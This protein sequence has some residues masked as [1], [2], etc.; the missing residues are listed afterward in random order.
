MTDHTH[1][2]NLTLRVLKRFAN[3]TLASLPE[4]LISNPVIEGLVVAVQQYRNKFNKLNVLEQVR[5]LHP[6]YFSVEDSNEISNEELLDLVLDNQY[7]YN[8]QKVQGLISDSLIFKSKDPNF[9]WAEIVDKSL[10][11]IKK[12]SLNDGFTS[13]YDSSVYSYKTLQPVMKFGYD[14]LDHY[15]CGGICP[16]DFIIMYGSVNSGK[17]TSATAHL[18][19]SAL[20]QGKTPLVVSLEGDPI[21]MVRRI[22]SAGVGL[23]DQNPT[24]LLGDQLLKLNDYAKTLPELVVID[25][26]ASKKRQMET[27][28]GRYNPDV[29]IYDQITI[30]GN[31]RDFTEM[32]KTSDML[33]Q[34]A[35]EYGIPVIAL[36]QSAEKN[37]GGRLKEEKD[38]D[39]Q[40]EVGAIK[41]SQALLE[42]ATHVVHIGLHPISS[43]KRLL[44]I[45]KTKDDKTQKKITGGDLLNIVIEMTPN[46]M[47]DTGILDRHKFI[48]K[49]EIIIPQ[50]EELAQNVFQ[51]L[52]KKLNQES[53]IEIPE[54]IKQKD[55]I[56]ESFDQLVEEASVRPVK[57]T[58]MLGT[59]IKTQLGN[60][61][62]IEME[63]TLYSQEVYEGTPERLKLVAKQANNDSDLNRLADFFYENIH[64]YGE[65][66]DSPNYFITEHYMPEYDANG[67][68]KPYF[69]GKKNE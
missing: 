59:T 5:I 49:Q 28:I 64:S 36:T 48:S 1:L 45:I 37:Y 44:S 41:Y 54:D 20:R 67:V 19:I 24:T 15:L 52:E 25:R 42:D 34:I 68:Y 17:T 35:Q 61:S 18:A 29:I 50:K 46:G 47:K 69:L 16:K 31:G 26:K 56:I 21:K 38:R 60:I 3:G 57:E 4:I 40:V 53:F 39:H 62:K 27:Y 33:K 13:S 22:M 7:K 51:K 2:D 32:A 8:L 14:L 43:N 66:S 55:E 30:S 11:L 23:F 65:D 63:T 58:P 12:G 6:S 10:E 9:K